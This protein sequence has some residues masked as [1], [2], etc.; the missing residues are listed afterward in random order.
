MFVAG[1]DAGT[2]YSQLIVG[3]EVTLAGEL[4]IVFD[5]EKFA[6]FDYVA[7]AGQTFDLIVAEEGIT[8]DPAGIELLNF[9]TVAGSQHLRDVTLTSYDSGI[10]ADPDD[11]LLITETLFSIELVENSTILRATLLE[12]LNFAIVPEPGSMALCLL[13]F[14]G[15]VPRRLGCRA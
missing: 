7:E 14:I 10:L 2:N 3:E 11:L 4:Q 5:L 9:V 1:Q 15:L 12:D 6:I 8:F 13:A